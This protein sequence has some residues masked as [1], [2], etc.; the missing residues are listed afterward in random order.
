MIHYTYKCPTAITIF[1]KNSNHPKSIKGS[2]VTI[3]GSQHL[4]YLFKGLEFDVGEDVALWHG[5]DLEGHCT[6]VVLQG[7]DI[8]IAHGQ[9]CP[10]VNLIPDHKTK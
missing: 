2:C 4:S 6:V 5:E 1:F 10:S 8:V 9:L 7:G 3:V